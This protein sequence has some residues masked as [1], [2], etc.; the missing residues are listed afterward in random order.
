[1]SR[2]LTHSRPD[3]LI[4]TP[5]RLM[6][7]RLTHSRPDPLILTPWRL[8]SYLE[9][10]A[11]WRGPRRRWLGRP[12]EEG[13]MRPRIPRRGLSRPG[14]APDGPPPPPDAAP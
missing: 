14:D 9:G 6:S 1:M 4:L 3:P 11:R 10:A 8:M 5:W 13:D 2:R 12:E 7:R